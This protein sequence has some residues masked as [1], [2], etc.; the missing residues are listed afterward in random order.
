MRSILAYLT[1]P[2]FLSVSGISIAQN[3]AGSY[4][5][6]FSCHNE[7]YASWTESAHY[8]SLRWIN[9]SPPEY[10][11]QF[12][13]GSPNVPD[14]P[15]VSGNQLSWDD[16]S[17]VIG[18]YRWKAQFLDQNG[19]IITGEAS[20]SAQWNIQSEQ[21]SIFHPGE[22]ME[23]DCGV[24][25]AMGYNPEGNQ[26]GFPGITGTWFEDDVGCE[27]CHGPNT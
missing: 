10:P 23:F 13:P 2:V 17:L 14:P 11:F 21:W 25:H 12:N 3:Y 6:G 22:Q 8:N 24:C 18:G 5:C 26:G 19:Y 20:D 27:A 9:G 16:V 1:I 15:Y 4:S 7:L